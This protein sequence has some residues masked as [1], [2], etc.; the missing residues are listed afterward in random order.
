MIRF[1]NVAYTW[2]KNSMIIKKMHNGMGDGQFSIDITSQKILDAKY[3]WFTL[4]KNVQMYC[5]SC[6]AYE[7]TWNLSLASVAH[8]VTTL[9]TKPFMKLGIDFIGPIK[10]IGQTTRDRFILMVTDYATKWVE[11]KA[12]RNNITMVTTKFLY[13]NI[14][15]RF[16]CP[17]ILSTIKVCTSPIQRSKC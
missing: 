3:Q 17:L 13:E 9:P 8:L 4:H 14:L 11:T 16:E 15:T 6:D 1:W 2:K 10:L 7:H 5:Q 12:L